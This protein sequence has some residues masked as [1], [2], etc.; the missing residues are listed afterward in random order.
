MGD[1]VEGL[2]GQALVTAKV[3]AAKGLWFTKKCTDILDGRHVQAC[4]S[5]IKMHQVC[6]ILDEILEA[7]HNLVIEIT[8]GHLCHSSF[9][10]LLC[11]YDLLFSVIEKFI[12][13]EIEADEWRILIN[14]FKEAKHELRPDIWP[15]DVQVFQET[16][17]L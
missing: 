5:Q 9:Y 10:L 3:Q 12:V 13:G 2:L 8:Q 17:H 15:A 7:R 14:L 16:A 4:H 6:V 11:Q 1:P